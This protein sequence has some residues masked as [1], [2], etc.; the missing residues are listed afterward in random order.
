M[1]SSLWGHRQ[2]EDENRQKQLEQA[3]LTADI[4]VPEKTSADE[5]ADF[6]GDMEVDVVG[7]TEDIPEVEIPDS[8]KDETSK[9]GVGEHARQTIRQETGKKA[10]EILKGGNN[11]FSKTMEMFGVSREGS[12]AALVHSTPFTR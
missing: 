2:T 1:A 12:A 5:I 10:D 4:A 6:N 8:A 9:M 3:A 7:E 11:L